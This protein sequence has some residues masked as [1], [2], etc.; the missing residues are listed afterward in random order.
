[1]ALALLS[2]ALSFPPTNLCSFSSFR[3]LQDL[4]LP[5]GADPNLARRSRSLAPCCSAERS[6]RRGRA[7]KSNAE[8]YDEL[9]EFISTVGL[10]ADRTPSMKE[11]CENGRKDLANIVRRRGY[12]AIRELLNS[13]EVIHSDKI[14]EGNQDLLSENLN[15]TA[16]DQDRNINLS[17]DC[18]FALDNSLEDTIETNRIV[19]E[20]S[21]E[22]LHLK[23]KKFTQTGELVTVEGED[24]ELSQDLNSKVYELDIQNETDHLKGLMDQNEVELSQVKQQIEDEKIALTN[25]HAKGADELGDMQR[26][27]AEKDIHLSM[28]KENLTGLKEVHIDYLAN[29]QIVEVAGSFNGWQHRIRM[30]L[31]P[32]S[33]GSRNQLLW[34]TVLWLY[35]GVYEIKFIV[36]GQWR[37]DSQ[38]EI[39]ICG[40]ITNNVLRVDI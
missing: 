33:P 2:S 37:I 18:T 34:T 11:L 9:R 6:S 30:N 24:S 29:G 23:A 22:F 17:P 40:S 39:A 16:G 26:L 19:C 4:R 8:L 1:M 5:S 10:P 21:E 13:N 7:S 3:K 27:L 38:L 35:P 12:K 28:A 31:H 14:S 15:E 25:L 32:S 36:D 20:G